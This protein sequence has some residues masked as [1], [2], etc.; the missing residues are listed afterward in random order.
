MGTLQLA[1]QSHRA[2][3]GARWSQ[4]VAQALTYA[5]L[6]LGGAVMLVPFVYMVSTALKPGPQV[7]LFPPVWIP[8]P[9]TWSNLREAWN[10]VG[11]RTFLNT[12]IFAASIVF[13]QGLVTTMG[14][15]GFSRLR[16]PGREVIFLAYLGTMMIPQQVTMIPAY[17]V[18][19]KLGWQDSYQGL[20]IPILASGAFGTFLFRQFFSQIPEDLSDAAFVDGAHHLTIYTRI[21]LP[22]SKPALTAY[23]T[24]TLLNAWNMYVWP[25]I[26][27]QSQKLWVLTLALSTLQG[28]LGSQTNIL[29]A[30]V[31]LSVL[32]LLVFYLF[33]QRLFVEGVTM[34][35]IKG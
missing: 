26:V 20:I 12:V 15:Y 34:T 3:F 24:I 27:V 2:A 22:L 29:L 18:V 21:F 4:R 25:L 14:G 7:F 8:N 33:G 5:F 13:G 32:P 28:D 16:F 19:V 9:P 11:F 6:V 31:M 23:G 35:G 30:A 17:I 10:V 1:T